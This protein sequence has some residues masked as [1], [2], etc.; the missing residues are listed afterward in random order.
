MPNIVVVGGLTGDGFLSSANLCGSGLT[1]DYYQQAYGR[2][3]HSGRDGPCGEADMTYRA[4]L[5]VPISS[6]GSATSAHLNVYL[7]QK[8][9]VTYGITLYE[10]TD[11]GTLDRTNDWVYSVR[12]NLGTFMN[13]GSALG[14]H[15]VDITTRV[16]AAKTAGLEYIA[17]TLVYQNEGESTPAGTSHWYAFAAADEATYISYRPY[18][19]YTDLS[20]PTGLTA[21][22]IDA[23][24]VDLAWID[25]ATTE[26]MQYVYRDVDASGTFTTLV[27]VGANV[28]SYSDTTTTSDHLY[29]YKVRAFDGSVYSGYSNTARAD[30][31]KEMPASTIGRPIP[32]CW[33]RCYNISPVQIRQIVPYVYQFHD[34]NYGPVQ[35]IDAVYINGYT[36]PTAIYATSLTTATVTFSTIPWGPVTMDVQGR[37]ASGTYLYKAADILKDMLLT[38]SSVTAAQVNTTAFTAHLSAVP[39]TIGIYITE[40]QQLSVYMDALLNGLLS[41]YG[42]GPDNKWTIR[43]VLVPDALATADLTLEDN[44]NL[45]DWS[46]QALQDIYYRVTLQG[47][48]NWTVNSNP[49]TSVT[50][51][52]KA[53][54]GEQYRQA[55]Q[56]DPIVLST[57]PLATESGPHET[58][59]QSSTD[60]ESAALVILQN[61]GTQRHTHRAS[62]K[63]PGLR[64]KLGD[65]L[66]LPRNKW[67]MGSGI[68]GAITGIQRQYGRE[69]LVNLEAL[70]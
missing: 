40:S 10:I 53:W 18:L 68:V 42:I 11:F 25:N 60:L 44:V 51:E 54:L 17:F 6:I 70:V 3:T 63:T 67:G 62:T 56:E 66:A 31:N 19:S 43:Q 52:R 26:T 4:Y 46:T 5:R 61:Y 58:L 33:G 36:A 13:T 23:N 9:N 8:Y 65:V 21:E 28:E 20:T 15:T 55:Y 2:V 29:D 32:L 1:H 38:F 35:S 14:W 24:H 12:A 41:F 39:Y 59:L 57:W 49:S 27:G 69:V 64:V 47:V 45:F 34:P 22:V 37:V 48:R 50:S 16:Q 7:W 30:T